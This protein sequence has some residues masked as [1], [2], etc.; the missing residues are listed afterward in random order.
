[1]KTMIVKRKKQ[2][3]LENITNDKPQTVYFILDYA[4]ENDLFAHKIHVQLR[5]LGL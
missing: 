3:L 1:M 2:V 4:V 5:F